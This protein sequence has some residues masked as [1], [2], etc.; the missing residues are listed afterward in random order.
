MLINLENLQYVMGKIK[1]SYYNQGKLEIETPRRTLG[2]TFPK[3][4]CFLPIPETPKDTTLIYNGIIIF[5]IDCF[6]KL[7]DWYMI[8]TVAASKLAGN[9]YFHPLTGST[10]PNKDLTSNVS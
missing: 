4:S 5:I 1:R 6:I 3:D 7:E 8:E 9:L 10:S 2:F